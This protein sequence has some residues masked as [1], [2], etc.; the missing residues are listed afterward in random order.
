MRLVMLRIRRLVNLFF[1]ST[2]DREIKSELE[3]HIE[4]RVE[5]NIA[6]GMSPENAKRDALIRFGSAAAMKERVISID[7]SLWLASFW[8]DLRYAFRRLAKSPGFAATA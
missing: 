2:L 7:A 4:M 5:D 8:A 6:C 1:R 3:A